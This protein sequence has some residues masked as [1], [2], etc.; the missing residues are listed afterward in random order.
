MNVLENLHAYFPI[1]YLPSTK[2]SDKSVEYYRRYE[3]MKIGEKN[4]NIGEYP[5]IQTLPGY[6]IKITRHRVPEYQFQLYVLL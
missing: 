3:G 2:F 6:P 5:L 1:E 4:A